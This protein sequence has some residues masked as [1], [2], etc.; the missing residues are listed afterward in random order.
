MRIVFYPYKLGSKSARILSALFNTKRVRPHG[1]YRGRRND[2]VINWGNSTIP[3]WSA[4]IFNSPT[5]VGI[6]A[7][8]L[9]AFRKLQEAGV[10][11]PEF[12]TDKQQAISWAREGHHV[13][14]R[15]LLT[16]NSGA[17]L[18]VTDNPEEI[19]NAPLYTKRIKAKY[20]FRVHV[21]NG[22]IIDVQQ[23][24]RRNGVEAGPLVRNHS[25]GFIFA[26]QGVTAPDVVL[27]EAK[28]AVQSLGLDFGAVD[29]GY[30][31]RDNKSYIYE[32]NTAPGVEGSSIQIYQQA[33]AS[34]I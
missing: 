19:V 14:C 10:S 15:T 16:G 34:L 6:A 18:V 31:A 27:S 24:K 3:S 22:Q 1:R 5:A 20:E 11:I 28:K 30:V 26:R 21:W 9:K 12:T 23:K 33:I 2:L 29:I 4:R 8:K 13:Y 17:G 25:N 32:V 7:N